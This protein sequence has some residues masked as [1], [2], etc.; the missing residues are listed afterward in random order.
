MTKAQLQAENKNYVEQSN[1]LLQEMRGLRANYKGLYDLSELR[2][3]QLVNLDMESEIHHREKLEARDERDEAINLLDE[4]SE[5][6]DIFR[7]QNIALHKKVE[8][9]QEQINEL[10]SPLAEGSTLKNAYLSD[11]HTIFSDSGEIHLISDH[12]SLVINIIDFARDLPTIKR[13]V[14]EELEEQLEDIRNT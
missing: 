7:T 11:C 9:L 2:R 6:T 4:L 5:E 12:L 1:E 13:M 8:A 14:I 10:T 3:K